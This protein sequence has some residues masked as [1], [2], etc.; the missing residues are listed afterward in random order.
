M[1]GRKPNRKE[2]LALES[3]RLNPN[4]WLVVKIYSDYILL[5]HRHTGRQREMPKKLLR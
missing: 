5:E 3:C 1:M 2:K 4:N